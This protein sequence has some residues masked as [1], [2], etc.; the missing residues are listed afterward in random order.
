MRWSNVCLESIGY[1]LPEEVVT[2]EAIEARLV[3]LYEALK[4]GKGQLETLTGIRERRVWPPSPSM[5]EC[6][7]R[8]GAKA[9]SKAGIGGDR[10]GAVV[11]AGVCR[12][13]LEPATACAVAD[14][15]G[16][17]SDCLVYDVANAC[18]GVL[19]GMIEIANRIELGQIRAG[20]VVSAESSR[21]IVDATIA[22]M[23]ADRSLER[24]RLSFA[25]MTGGSGAVA[26]V[27][28]HPTLSD[29]QRRLVGG[30]VLAETRH[31]LLCRWGPEAGLLGVTPNRMETDAS[32][33]MVHGVALGKRTWERFLRELEWRAED[34][35]KVI[36]HQ[37][38]K[39][40]RSTVLDALGIPEAKDYSTF[41]FL[42]NTGTVAL[43]ITAARADE[44]GFLVSGDR[45]GFLGIGSGLNCMMLGVRW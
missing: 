22:R 45:V 14:R 6:A 4:L 33:V 2:S 9:L 44:D 41:D 35:D 34:V 15:L 32:Q 39:S 17:P 10:L 13:H 42:G 40:H 29:T 26:V 38:A 36:C 5:A 8:A 31:H 30:M 18:L 11:Y 7:A 43:P 37:V 20:I 23:V 27:L 16:A 25:T 3:P 24:Y 12:D 28:T 21:E 19:N 1:E